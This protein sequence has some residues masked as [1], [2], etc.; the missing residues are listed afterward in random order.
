MSE[1]DKDDKKK[2]GK[3][4]AEQSK[5]TQDSVVYDQSFLSAGEKDTVVQ[6]DVATQL[7][8]KQIVEDNS[9]K[10]LYQYVQ[11]INIQLDPAAKVVSNVQGKPYT[12][13]QKE[14][15]QEKMDDGVKE[16][17]GIMQL[18]QDLPN[19]QHDQTAKN[20]ARDILQSFANHGVKHDDPILKEEIAAL[21]SYGTKMPLP[22]LAPAPHAK[23]DPHTTKQ[24]PQSKPVHR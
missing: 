1:H 11:G 9:L 4:P 2:K 16:E 18:Y 23:A 22:V 6:T 15:I 13:K 21:E 3:Q 8:G 10:Q 24:K 12:Q 20:Y 5:P 19:N 17:Y 7:R 14:F